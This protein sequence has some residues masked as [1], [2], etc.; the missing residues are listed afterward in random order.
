MQSCLSSSGKVP[1]RPVKC[2]HIPGRLLCKMNDALIFV[3]LMMIM[4][5]DKTIV[6]VILPN[7]FLIILET[8]MQG[9]GT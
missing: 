3:Y 8:A 4:I 2:A 1:W 7:N 6:A 9:S 5:K